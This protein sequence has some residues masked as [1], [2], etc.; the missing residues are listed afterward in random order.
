MSSDYYVYTYA[1]PD[2]RVFYVGKGRGNR[3]WDHERDARNGVQSEKCDIIREIHAQGGKVFKKQLYTYLS[4]Q[5]AI[6]I[7]AILIALFGRAELANKQSG[8]YRALTRLKQV[9]QKAQ[10]K[11]ALM[12]FRTVYWN[13][14]RGYHARSIRIDES[15]HD[16]AQFGEDNVFEVPV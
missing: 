11:A 15:G 13:D 3:M 10:E 4:E 5:D 14:E 6:A 8:H 2:G 16:L 9:H 1:Y 12:L 7:E